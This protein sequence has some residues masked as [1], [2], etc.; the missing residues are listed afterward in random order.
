MRLKQNAWVSEPV[1]LGDKRPY[2][3]CLI[4]PDFARLEAAATARG[5]QWTTRAQLVALPQVR[6]LFEAGIA[7]IN[8]TLAPFETIKRFAVLDHE[9]TQENGMLTATLKVKRRAVA[10]QH[11][12]VIEA[13]YVGHAIAG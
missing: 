9:L 4:A 2:V 13:L 7:E 1:L 8:G 12:S 10:E 11:A 5:W 6:A 3:V